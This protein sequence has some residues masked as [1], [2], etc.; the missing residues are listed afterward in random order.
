V[1]SRS[2]RWSDSCVDSFVISLRTEADGAYRADPSP[3][4]I[5]SP[6]AR[7]LV[8]DDD[9]AGRVGLAKLLT[10]DGYLVTTASSG[11]AAIEEASRAFPDMVITDV[12][13]PGMHG[14]ALCKRLR[15]LDAE[16][17]VIVMT[18]HSDTESAVESLRA[19]ATDY[20]VKPL[21]YDAV[22]W[23]V[24]RTLARR[25]ATRELE[26]L[27]K[28]HEQQ[29]EEFLALVSHDLLNPLSNILM[30]VSLL[31]ESLHKQG[32]AKDLKLAERAERNVE[33]MT[34]MLEE[35]TEATSLESRQA[36]P[37]SLVSCD[38][39]ELV[40]G[41]VDGMNEARARRI[42]VER[43]VTDPPL[44]LADPGRLERIIANLLT[45]A[46]KYSADDAPVVARLVR[47]GA[48]IELSITDR[49]IGIPAESLALL[50]DRYFR[51]KG[52]KARASGLGLG[53]Y[54]ARLMVETL[55]GRIDVASELGAGSTF[56][57][58]L[59]ALAGR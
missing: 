54:I 15:E 35:L 17:P 11:E 49:G 30:C 1:V 52:G 9:A 23:L 19:G 4:V 48:S 32:L 13:M 36:A 3:P 57:V 41:I 51:A 18:G 27:E 2:E 24:Q 37:S 45:N 44:V 7:V 38:L 16:L 6:Q 5:S 34:A 43:D 40:T 42:S 14:V 56:T 47:C 46:L 50:F 33:R 21:S 26:R 59:P 39:G 31:K 10:L 53:L 25:A 8:V 12:E 55:G 58:T 20:L 22:L 29:R 28:R